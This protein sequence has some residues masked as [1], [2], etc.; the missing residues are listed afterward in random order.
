MN[1]EEILLPE[2]DAAKVDAFV[3]WFTGIWKSMQQGFHP[4]HEVNMQAAVDAWKQ[5][6]DENKLAVWSK[7]A[8]CGVARLDE[9]K[10]YH[11]WLAEGVLQV[12]GV[13]MGLSG[14][15]VKP[16]KVVLHSEWS[17]R[18]PKP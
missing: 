13:P 17:K 9:A 6:P 18:V 5:L 1:D 11:K 7:L 16:R 2:P 10:F 12:F 4:Q 8:Q 15:G 3:E 14:I